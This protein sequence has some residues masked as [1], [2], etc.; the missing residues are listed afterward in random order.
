MTVQSFTFNPFQTN[1][2]VCHDGGEA[3]LVDAPGRTPAEHQ[4]VHDYLTRHG[5]TVRHLLLTHAHIDHVFG[6]AYWSEQLKMPW[7]MHRED[8]PFITRS[9]EQAQLFGIALEAPPLPETFLQEG[10]TIT[11]GAATWQVLY[12]PGHSPG[13]VSFHDAAHG[14]VIAGDVLFH[15]SIGRTDLPG[16]SMPVLMQSI[17]QQLLPLG[18][19]TAV[20]CG[21]GPATKIGRE[22]RNNPFLTEQGGW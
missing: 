19:E 10:D 17:F 21:H 1:G 22:R 7:Q 18:D 4:A 8:L 6:C 11:F 5:L 9:Q 14:F 12:T 2:F 15:G 16:G 13:S 20:Y 3:V